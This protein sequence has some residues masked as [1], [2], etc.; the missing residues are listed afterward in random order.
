CS[1]RPAPTGL[2]ASRTA[3]VPHADRRVRRHRRAIAAAASLAADLRAAST[4]NGAQRR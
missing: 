3:T 4:G 1:R 2:R